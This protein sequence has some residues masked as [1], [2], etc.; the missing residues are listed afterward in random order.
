[1]NGGVT[2]PDALF[3]YGTLMFPEVLDVLLGRTPDM[4]PA[5]LDGWRAAALA[6]RVYPGL[7]AANRPGVAA[8]GRVLLGLDDQERVVLDAFE[9]SIYERRSVVLADGRRASTYV[10]LDTTAVLAHDWDPTRFATDHLAVYVDHWSSWR[11]SMP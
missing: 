1:L 8:A 7:V 10:W 9:E 3:V 6:D 4:A 2:E 5:A 11:R